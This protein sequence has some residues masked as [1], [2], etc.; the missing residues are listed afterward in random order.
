M[1]A[2]GMWLLYNNPGTRGY[3]LVIPKAGGLQELLLTK[4]YFSDLSGFLGILKTL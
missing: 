2:H 4:L 1:D 3:Q